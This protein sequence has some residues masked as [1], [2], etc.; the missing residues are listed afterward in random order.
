[1]GV[2]RA[3]GPR[4]PARRRLRA[5]QR[6]DRDQRHRDQQRQRR[7]PVVE[8]AVPAEDGGARGRASTLQ[9]SCVS[10]GQLRR[11]E[12]PRR[13]RHRRPPRPRGGALVAREGGRDLP[14]HPRLRRLPGQG[15]QR[16][17]ARAA[18]LRPHACRRGERARG[19]ARP[20]RGCRDVARVR[21]RRER[22]P[23]PREAGLRGV[24]AARRALPRQR[25]RAGQERAPRLPAPRALPSS[26][27]GDAAHAADGRAA[28]HA[29]VPRTIHAPRL[30]GADV[31][32]VPR[33]GH[34]R[35][36]ARLVGG[37]GG[38]RHARGPCA[39]GHRRRGQHRPRHQL[40]RPRLRAGGR[41]GR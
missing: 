13:P 40:V 32:G 37:P 10:L 24:R 38:G 39:H 12:G 1:M 17:P 30:P 33:R 22:G 5:R 8:R 36:G 6:L 27:W 29:G 31:E 20:S 16:G 21:L 11:P 28:G 34:V 23:R 4:R 19:R 15:Q 25:V 26:L 7:P 3:A 9:P 14:A 41:S 2:G 18:G 35:P